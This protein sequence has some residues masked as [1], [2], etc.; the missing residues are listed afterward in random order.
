MKVGNV[1]VQMKKALDKVESVVKFWGCL[2]TI[3]DLK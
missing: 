2:A 1:N 3:S